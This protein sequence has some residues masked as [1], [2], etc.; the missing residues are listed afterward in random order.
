MNKSKN[1]FR[2]IVALI[3]IKMSSRVEMI[4]RK[5]TNL[6]LKYPLIIL[7]KVDN[8]FLVNLH[9]KRQT[10]KELRGRKGKFRLYLDLTEI[11]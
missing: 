1:A 3:F 4:K 9:L 7:D 2:D 11:S 6:T 8:F 10:V 5:L